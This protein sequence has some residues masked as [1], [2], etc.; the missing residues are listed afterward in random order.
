MFIDFQEVKEKVSIEHV[1]LMLKLNV[2]KYGNQ[3]RGPCPRCKGGGD[4]ALVIT[5]G[6]GYYC[7]ANKQ[8]GDSIA[9]AAHILDL[10][11]KG[12]AIAIATFHGLNDEQEQA[13]KE[14]EA[15]KGGPPPALQPLTYLEGA[16]EAV[17]ALGLSSV[18]ADSIGIGYAKKGIM[19]GRVAIPLRIADGTLIGYVGYSADGSLRFPKNLVGGES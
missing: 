15:E 17:Q 19:R 3:W 16:H 13:L 8:G 4:R 6:K 5:E 2:T 9:L 12:A 10:T 11:P 14:E 18:V 1:V 7:F